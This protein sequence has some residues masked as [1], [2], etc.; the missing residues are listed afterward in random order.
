MTKPTLY[1][2]PH[3]MCLYCHNYL[4]KTFTSKQTNKYIQIWMSDYEKG[5][6]VHQAQRQKRNNNAP[7]SS[8]QC[9]SKAITH[10]SQYQ[11]VLE[12]CSATTK[13]VRWQEEYEYC[14]L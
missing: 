11:R 5:G 13:S 10:L 8:V 1:K 4:W 9:Y 12:N 2:E 6:K 3:T 14:T 7:P